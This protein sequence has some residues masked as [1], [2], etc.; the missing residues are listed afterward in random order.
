MKNISFIYENKEYN[1]ILE[2]DYREAFN[3]DD[4]Q[5]KYTDYFINYDYILGDYASD[6]LRLKGFNLKTNK[7]YNKVNDYNKINDYIDKYCNYG[8]KYFI[9]KSCK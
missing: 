3:L 2:K 6:S 5:K 4:F 8:C 1:Y 9:L 7:N